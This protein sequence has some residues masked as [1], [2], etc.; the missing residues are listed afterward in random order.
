[1]AHRG[2]QVR[3]KG[4]RPARGFSWALL[5]G[6]LASVR[7]HARDR[8]AAAGFGLDRVE[9]LVGPTGLGR[10]RP[11]LVSRLRLAFVFNWNG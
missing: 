1:M 3:G 2:E 8:T 7:A 10:S 11:G 5:G 4:Y 6:L 9:R